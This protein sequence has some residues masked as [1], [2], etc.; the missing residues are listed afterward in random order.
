VSLTLLVL[1]GVLVLGAIV[2]LLGRFSKPAASTQMSDSWI[3]SRKYDRKHS[4]PE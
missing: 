2:W 1:G 4:R 3:D